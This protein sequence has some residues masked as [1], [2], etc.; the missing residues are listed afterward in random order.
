[1]GQ[2]HYRKGHDTLQ[3]VY[4]KVALINRVYM[5]GFSRCVVGTVATDAELRVSQLLL[6]VEMSCH[7]EYGS[8]TGSTT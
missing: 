1:M 6:G 3:G 5:A 8:C 4:A 7:R 2:I